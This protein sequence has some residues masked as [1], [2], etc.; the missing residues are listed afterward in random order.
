MVSARERLHTDWSVSTYRAMA[1]RA[2]RR[3]QSARAEGRNG[4][5]DLLA[6]AA[7]VF[8]EQG[9]RRASVEAIAERAGY[10]KGAVY[11]H[12][13]SKEEVFLALLE[14]RIEHL[15]APVAGLGK[16]ELATVL[17]CLFTGLAQQK[18]IEP[19][20]VPDRL[21]GEAIALIYRGAV[22]RAQDS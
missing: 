15:G 4:R 6:A 12:F 2:D 7:E 5:A 9:F 11:W 10:S 14:E 13:E 18:L 16:D 3:S 17:I 8:A 1:K 22:A 19:D 21:L 20:S